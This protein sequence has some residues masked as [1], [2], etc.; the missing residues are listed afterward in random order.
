M[1]IM[2]LTGLVGFD[3][4]RLA[5][6]MLTVEPGLRGAV[7]MGPPGSGKSSIM[8]AFAQIRPDAP[9]VEVP[10][11][12]DRDALA[13]GLDAEA[14]VRVGKRIVRPGLLTRAHGGVLIVENFT[15]LGEGADSLILQTIDTGEV[16]IEREGLS[17]VAPAQFTL[18]ASCDP[19]EGTARAHF[20]DRAGLIVA[21]PVASD[22]KSRLR[23]ARAHFAPASAEWAEELDLMRGLVAVARESISQIVMSDDAREQ[24]ASAAVSLGVEGH[25]AD[26][27]AL[28]AARASAALGLRESIDREDI[29]LAIRLVLIPRATRAPERDTMSQ[30]PQVEQEPIE[31]GND[32][33][34]DDEAPTEF[35]EDILDAILVSQPLDLATLHFVSSRSARSGSRGS[36]GG[37][38]GRHVASVAGSPK[39]GRLD[40]SATLRASAPWQAFR[41]HGLS[42]ISIIPDDFRIKRY[43]SKAGALFVFAVDASGSM[44]L[45]R[46]REAKGAVH[47]LLEQ[48]YVNR[49]RVALISFR[50]QTAELLMPPTG[51]V[52]LLRRAVDRIPT[53]GATPIASALVQAMTIADQAQ[54][55]GFGN[56]V[57][58]MLTDGKAN[59]GLAA[60]RAGVDAELKLLANGARNAGLTSLLIDTQRS[61]LDH[62]A[63]ERLA[64]WL[65]GRYLYLPGAGSKDIAAAA[66]M[67]I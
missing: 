31:S 21:M 28:L 32:D 49:D 39:R 62:S 65:G 12:C 7:F 42:R 17:T 14:T 59:C 3:G 6:M 40:L 66:R 48:A 50:G 46:M 29:E 60:D 25:R 1:Q 10:V 54:R 4:P 11:G 15:L 61:F 56:C 5:L 57:L 43:K 20:L 55:R 13:G 53:G 35:N 16:K 38:R 64:G 2:P 19:G 47:A 8:R 34:A 18:L 24:L 44:A 23:V 67:S 41:R 45:N 63:G 26:H 52:E 27:F 33:G 37:N 51:S 36:T 30:Q 22:A 58:V 9:M